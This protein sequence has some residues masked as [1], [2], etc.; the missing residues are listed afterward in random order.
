MAYPSLVSRLQALASVVLLLASPTLTGC[1][2]AD[3]SRS[4]LLRVVANFYPVQFLA[5]G[6]GG[7]AVNVTDLTPPGTEPHDL[8]LDGKATAALSDANVVFYLGGGFQPDVEK[9]VAEL[10]ASVR[11]TDLLTGP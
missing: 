8:A 4:R 11:R 9:A 2:R 10:A 5:Q 6:V 1:G 7:E 3:A